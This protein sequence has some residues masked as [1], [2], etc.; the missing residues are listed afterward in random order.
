[1]TRSVFPRFLP[2]SLSTDG[3]W[4]A[5][6]LKPEGEL[7]RPEGASKS[8]GAWLFPILRSVLP[9]VVLADWLF[10]DR[11]IGLSLALFALAIVGSA[12]S[13]TWT[14]TTR[15]TQIRAL[16]VALLACLP[17]VNAIGFFPILFLLLGTIST[18][19][20]LHERLTKEI[21]RNIKTLLW[22]MGTGPI[23]IILD[24]IT[25]AKEMDL[26]VQTR[27]LFGAWILPVGLGL[28]F[29][30]L[31]AQANPV[32]ETVILDHLNL[33]WLDPALV[34]RM[35]FWLGVLCLCWPFIHMRDARPSV[36]KQARKAVTAPFWLCPEAIRNALLLFNALF[37]VQTAMDLSYLWG[38]VELPDGMTYAS[39]AHRGAYPLLVTSALAG[40]FMLIATGFGPLTPATKGLLYLWIAQ[41][42]WLVISAVLRLNLYVA[43]YSLTY[44]R[45]AAFIW[46]ALVL[47]G[48]V[49]IAIRLRNNRSNAWVVSR[50]AGTGLLTLYLGCFVNF[51]DMI[52]HYNVS[53]SQEMSGHGLKLDRRYLCSLGPQAYP[54]ADRFWRETGSP[55]AGFHGSSGEFAGRLADGFWRHHQSWRD[56]GLR[57][58]RLARYLRAQFGET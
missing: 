28:I 36:S 31:F 1:M 48:L 40:L 54:A 7:P 11:Y 12:M 6:Q 55:I 44:L 5:S 34:G 2:H 45:V 39:Y 8:P 13:L 14:E 47:V 46:M 23:W 57:D 17:T 56:W 29:L 43:F 16:G 38:G 50:I 52:A 25:P 49:L 9:L 3:W 21:S 33:D 32:L 42:L 19:L 41:N 53:H 37:V 10:W 24:A 20:I 58:H 18:V 15:R 30:A 35:I 26:E 22:F 27:R 4:L 51:A